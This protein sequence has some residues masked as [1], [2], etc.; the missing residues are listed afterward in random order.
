M[1]TTQRAGA[2]YEAM[3]EAW[4]ADGFN[5]PEDPSQLQAASMYL[6]IN[7]AGAKQEGVSQ[8]L[9]KYV[10]AL[11]ATLNKK[12]PNWYES[13]FDDHDWCKVCG[14]RYRWENLSMCTHCSSPFCPSH[15]AS[16]GTAPNGNYL[17]SKCGVG[18]IVG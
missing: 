9:R 11:W 5:T 18:E 17:C 10:D 12:N 8:R 6:W 13:Q 15:G 16:G 1:D 3:A 14:E 7:S 4:E 2:Q